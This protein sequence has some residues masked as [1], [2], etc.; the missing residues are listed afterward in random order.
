[1]NLSELSK[2]KLTQLKWTTFALAFFFS[3]MSVVQYWFVGVQIKAM[4]TENLQ[5]KSQKINKQINYATAPDLAGYNKVYSG[6]NAF[7]LINLDGTVIDTEGANAAYVPDFLP[8][9]RMPWLKNSKELPVTYVSPLGERWLL[10]TTPIEGG[11]GVLGISE[12]DSES[13]ATSASALMENAKRL[14]GGVAALD[15]YDP[16]KLDHKIHHAVVSLDGKLLRAGGR[17]PFQVDPT[18]VGRQSTESGFKLANNGATYYVLYSPLTDTQGQPVGTMAGFQD[19]SQS[20]SA[21]QNMLIFSV[22]LGILSFIGFLVVSIASLLRHES[23]KQKIRAAFQNYF[24]PKIPQ[25]MFR[26][27]QNI[28]GQP[29]E[30]TIMFSDIRSFVNLR[31]KLPSPQLK[32]ML[33]EYFDGMTEEVVATEGI[34]DRYIGDAVM[35]FWGAPIDQADHADR[36]VL[37]A[38]GMIKRLERLKEKWASEGIPASEIGIVINLGVAT[39]ADVG[40]RHRF[41]Y[42]L[43]GEAVNEASSLEGLNKQPNSHILISESTKNHLTLAVE[44]RGLGEVEL[45][46]REG[47][48]R[49]FEVKPD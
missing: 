30:V 26:E 43:I 15:H 12:F 7:Q 23:E 33:Q 28:E 16:S 19:T 10:L 39:L 6:L 2:P 45:R 48:I 36:A 17:I 31:D 18:A 11:F 29:Q 24:A 13:D 47:L 5:L 37:A 40:S 41:D 4:I 27:Q 8:V 1:M 25:T 44:T 3:L 34:V 49:I 20:Q 14:P 38:K 9:V 22:A 42:T 21:I 46:D 35:A 32:R